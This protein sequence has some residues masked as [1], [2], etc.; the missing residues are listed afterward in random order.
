LAELSRAQTEA[1]QKSIRGELGPAEWGQQIRSY[2]LQPYTMVKD[3]RTLYETGN[4]M[5]V[6]NGEIQGFIEAYLRDPK[7]EPVAED[8]S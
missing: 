4:T 2:V 1:D 8:V 3:L 5:G 6:L 7:N